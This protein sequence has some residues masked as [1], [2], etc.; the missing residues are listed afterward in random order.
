LEVAMTVEQVLQRDD[1]RRSNLALRERAALLRERSRLVREEAEVTCVRAR[2]LATGSAAWRAGL[3]A[4]R[5]PEPEA[6]VGFGAGDA[7]LG[8]VRVTELFTVL[9]ERH[10]FGV[11]EAVRALARGLLVAG[12]PTETEVV[13]AAD[14]FSIV[15]WVVGPVDGPA[16]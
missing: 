8:E 2:R 3:Q 11:I 6:V 15:E 1:I 9:V 4:L 5:A 16:D 7:E 10:R 13:S 14:A 12:Y